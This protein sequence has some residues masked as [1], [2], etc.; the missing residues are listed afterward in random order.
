MGTVGL[1]VDTTA[2]SVT[3]LDA[4]C[5]NEIIFYAVVLSVSLSLCH[6]HILTSL[7]ANVDGPRD[8]ASCLI[9]HRAVHKSGC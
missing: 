7:S 9:D 5:Y 6:S 4:I 2:K 8:A 1:Q 3:L